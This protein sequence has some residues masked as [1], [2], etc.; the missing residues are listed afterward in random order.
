MAI[1]TAT[2]LGE[3]MQEE[4]DKYVSIGVYKQVAWERDIALEQLR[5]LGYSFGEK[6]EPSFKVYQ[7]RRCSGEWE[8]YHEH[9]VGCYVS[10]EKAIAEKERLELEEAEKCNC[11]E[12]PLYFC[13]PDCDHNCESCA[14]DENLAEKAKEFCKRYDPLEGLERDCRNRNFIY[15]EAWF[16][17]DEIEVVR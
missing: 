3:K 15:D 8:L 5:E 13:E 1:I 17:I 14:E 12:C 4:K 2:I 6:I 10:E 9:I 11:N 16:R 7:I